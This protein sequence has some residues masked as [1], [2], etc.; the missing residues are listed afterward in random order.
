MT[1]FKQTHNGVFVIDPL[2]AGLR[3]GVVGRRANSI[4]YGSDSGNVREREK[5]LIRGIAGDEGLKIMMLNQMH[6]NDII[7]VDAPPRADLCV[8]GDADGL[9]T[10]LPRVC[11]VIRSADCAPVFA[12]D[13]TGKILGAAHSG[14]RGTRLSVVRELVR[15]MRERYGSNNRDMHIFILPS[16]GPRSYVVGGDVAGLFPLDVTERD[17]SLY[18]NLWQRI[19]RDL[20]E[21]GIPDGNIFNTGVCTLDNNAEFFSYRGGDAGRNINYGYLVP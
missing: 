1:S 11:L 15:N 7:S 4:D 5:A 16:I 6:G 8:A 12:Y 9:S 2:P 10:R 17:G 20:R 3:I 18:L 13:G 14:W 19:E 21:E